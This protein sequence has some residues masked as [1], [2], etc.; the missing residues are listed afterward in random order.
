MLNIKE[1]L[2][3]LQTPD[4]HRRKADIPLWDEIEEEEFDEL[5]FVDLF[6]RQVTQPKKKE[7][8]EAKPA[9]AK[10]RQSIAGFC[11]GNLSVVYQGKRKGRREGK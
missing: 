1:C 11:K 3:D 7:K 5:E 6:A 9:K 4:H 8:K 2:K 10:V